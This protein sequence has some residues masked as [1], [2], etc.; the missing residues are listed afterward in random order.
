MMTPSPSPNASGS[1]GFIVE[2]TAA[3]SKPTGVV[4]DVGNVI[5]RWN[6]RSLY[7]KIFTDPAECDD[8][9]ENVC[10]LSWNAEFDRGRPMAEGIA[11]LT[12]Q[13][14]HHA[15]AIAAWKE[16][17]WETFTGPIPETTWAI[18]TLA[19]RGAPMFGLSNISA[20]TAAGTFAMHPCFDH[21]RIIVASGEVGLIKP[22][23]RIFELALERY[24]MAADELLFVDDN[25][26]NIETARSLGFH[27]HW[28]RDPAD[29]EPALRAHGLL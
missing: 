16:R 12:A 4:W 8:F 23:P 1:D 20:E 17:W 13:F 2:A 9:L 10:T 19:A 11:E 6:P 25:A 14:P 15:A 29:L 18:E 28:F 24:G 7:A 21:L 27:T 5:V 26:A 3:G 22:D